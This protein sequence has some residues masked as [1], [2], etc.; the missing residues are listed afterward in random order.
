MSLYIPK[1]LEEISKK[2]ISKGKRAILV[3][4]SVRDHFLG[5]SIKDYDIEVFGVENIEKLEEI[6]KNFGTI[7][8]VGKSFGVLKLRVKNFEFD[9]SIPRVEKKISKGHNG[10]IVNLKKDVNFKEATQR[11]DFTINAI[12]FD[13]LSKDF[14][15]P[16]NGIVDIKKGV[17]RHIDSKMFQED[18][19]RVYRGV[20]FVARFELKVEKDTF[21]LL[22]NMV[23]NTILDELPKER[24]Y[25]EIKKLFLKSKKP[26]IGIELMKELGILDKYFPELLNIKLK[27]IDR[28]SKYKDLKLIFASIGFFNP[29]Q[30]KQ[31]LSKLTDEKRF[32]DEVLNLTDTLIK[33]K[34]KKI[35]KKV[36][37]NR[38]STTTKVE[39]FLRLARVLIKI[40]NYRQVKKTSKRLNIYRDKPHPIIRGRDLIELGMRPSKEFKHI[41]NRLY[42]AQIEDKIN[43]PKDAFELLK[44]DYLQRS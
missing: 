36:D 10:F 12:G 43:S 25:I 35:L 3:G 9:F 22:Q 32:I 37:I 29:R 15:D 28:V 7:N 23:E 13:I 41:L 16:Q 19:L 5:L 21:I 11:R 8:L 17:L 14:L 27:S 26:S 34:D 1:E 20:Q 2:L 39:D 30:N 40:K 38:I 24:I 31:F 44:R 4:G 6:L 33:Y 42:Q 18:P